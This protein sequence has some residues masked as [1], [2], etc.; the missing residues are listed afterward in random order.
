VYT[1][2]GIYTPTLSVTD[3][4]GNTSSQAAMATVTV[5][6]SGSTAGSGSGGGAFGGA[7]L[8][9]MLLLAL[10]GRRCRQPMDVK[11]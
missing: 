1:A 8:L 11:R 5:I 6:G 7:T 10:R 9:P 2:A 3:S 4:Q